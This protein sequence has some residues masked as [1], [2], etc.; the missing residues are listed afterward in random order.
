VDQSGGLPRLA[1]LFLAKFLGRQFAQF[2]VN[3]R[4]ELFG[5]VR[6]ALFD[7]GQDAGDIGHA[8]KHNRRKNARPASGAY[9]HG[10]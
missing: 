4:Q 10:K 6:I 1:G 8:I 7:G 5:G 3:Q 9:T 2:V